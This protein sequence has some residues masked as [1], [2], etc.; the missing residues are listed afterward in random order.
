MF[1][2]DAEV[3]TR[4]GT[5]WVSGS[6]RCPAHPGDGAGI[7]IGRRSTPA[8]TTKR[9]STVRHSNGAPAYLLKAKGLSPARRNHKCAINLTPTA[10]EDGPVLP[11]G[12]S[13]CCF[14]RVR[15]RLGPDCSGTPVL[16]RRL[17]LRCIAIQPIG[18]AEAG[19]VV[20]S[21]RLRRGRSAQFVAD[22]PPVTSQKSIWRATI[23]SGFV[24][25]APEAGFWLCPELS[26]SG[27][28]DS[29]PRPLDPQLQGRH[30]PAMSTSDRLRP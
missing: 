12:G 26:S 16:R 13:H 9:T 5:R 19:A 3:R 2:G 11:R 6:W 23:V 22:G 8:S 1:L 14:L 24:R 27:W 4:K 25:Q 15:C 29:N 18:T 28:R 21:G 30:Y 10:L 17:H 7:D 20:V